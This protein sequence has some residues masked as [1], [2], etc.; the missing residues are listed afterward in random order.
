MYND[1]VQRY[2]D[3]M[4]LPASPE[5]MACYERMNSKIRHMPERWMRS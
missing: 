4:G 2:A 1:M 3:E 5:M